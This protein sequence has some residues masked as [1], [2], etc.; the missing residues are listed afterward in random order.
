MGFERN[1]VDSGISATEPHQTGEEFVRIRFGNWGPLTLAAFALG[2]APA[3]AQSEDAVGSWRGTLVAGPQELEIVFHLTTAED[4]SLTGTMDVPTQGATG[5]P[6]TTVSIEG[7]SV[8]WTFPVP[9]GGS[10]EGTVDDSGDHISGTFTQAGQG[11]PMDL[12]R[13]DG[14]AA[15][16]LRPQEPKAP[17]PYTVEE[18]SFD[19]QDVGITLAGTLT[20]PPGNGP[21][22]GVVLVSGSGPQDRDETVFGHR[23]FMVLADHLTRA[24]IAVLRYDDRGVGESG[25][26]FAAATSEDFTA[27][28]LAAVA[29]L[30][31]DHRVARDAIGIVGHSEGGIVGPLA[32]SRSTTVAHVVMLAGPGVPGIDVLVEQGILINEAAGTP[33]GM[34]SFN[35]RIQR[36]LAA[37]VAEESDAETAAELMRAAIQEEIGALEPGLREAAAAGFTDETVSRTISQMNSPWFRFFMHYD[38]RPALEETQVPVLAL[39]GGKDLQV[40][41]AQSAE[42]VEAALLRG[43]NQ[44]VTVRIMP[45]LNHLFQETATGSPSEYQTIE[46]TISPDAL[47][48][49]R[50]W[51]LE[52]FGS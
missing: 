20:L 12:E 35:T 50:L 23:P 7:S 19:N 49:V 22:P 16:L 45:G 32:A 2:S 10:Y 11:F 39:F 24:G 51:I 18:V 30:G 40:P 47:D 4:G 5:I 52:R 33:A 41:P 37:I 21:F 26:V 1:G 46:Q 31:A 6:L 13:S 9:G 42:E 34:T 17:F 48:V 3:Q 8:N 43:G 44:D 15:P 38:P 27:D 29:Y 28:A 36:G 25:G 14:E